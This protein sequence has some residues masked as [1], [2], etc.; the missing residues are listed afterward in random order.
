[1][2]IEKV[3]FGFFVILACTLNFGFFV[4]ELESITSHSSTELFAALVI[5]LVAII[6]K[7]GDRTQIG[8]LHL[9]TSFA[10]TLQLLL[11]ALIWGWHIYIAQLPMDGDTMSTIVSVSGGALI[12]NLVSVILLIG[13][14]LRHTR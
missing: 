9:A 12:A 3:V 14:T 5:N 6:L 7:L 4:G 13:E 1:M 10:A 8:A 2:N 11:S